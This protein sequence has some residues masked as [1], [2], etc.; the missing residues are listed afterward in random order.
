MFLYN[1]SLITTKNM[2]KVFILNF[3]VI[4]LLLDSSTKIFF[5]E[6]TKERISIF[7][8]KLFETSPRRLIEF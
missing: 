2:F 8:E 6:K 3:S 7:L 5:W 1:F 4:D